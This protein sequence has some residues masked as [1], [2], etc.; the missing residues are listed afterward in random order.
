MTQATPDE[1]LQF[2]FG[3]LKDGLASPEVRAR[4]FA[5]DT[6]FDAVCGTFRPVLDA[7]LD[8]R[9]DH[10]LIHPRSSLAY[11]LAC[12]QLPRNIFRGQAAA[13][14]WDPLALEAA[15]SAV[16]AGFDLQLALDERVFLYMPFEHS[17][18]LLD[19]H[20]AVGLFSALRDTSQGDAR[21]LMGSNLRFAQQHRDI[22]LK[23]GRF[24]HRNAVLER[25]STVPEQEFVDA[26]DG[27][28]QTT[29]NN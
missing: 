10:W 12:D 8:G 5:S 3:E 19:Q 28:G 25:T 26:G 14:R 23:Y 1:I 9:L 18:N 4:W 27:F 11:I 24:P 29:N 17:E 16:S 20:T 6:D 22:I 7:I 15:K 2:W 21:N 13:F